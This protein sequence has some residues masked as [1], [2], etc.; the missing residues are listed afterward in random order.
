MA[1]NRVQIVGDRCNLD[2]V[3]TN[4]E[5]ENALEFVIGAFRSSPEERR[6]ATV[7]FNVAGSQ[8]SLR[9]EFTS[10]AFVEHSIKGVVLQEGL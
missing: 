6:V 10:N 5:G 4:L 1:S 2:L 8:F 3:G 7:F 9:F